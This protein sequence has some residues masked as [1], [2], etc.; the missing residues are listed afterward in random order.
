MRREKSRRLRDFRKK[1]SLLIPVCLGLALAVLTQFAAP[2]RAD[3]DRSY[4]FPRVLIEAELHSDGSMTVVEA[5]SYTHLDVYK[6]QY[7]DC[8]LARAGR[9]Q[10]AS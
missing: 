6:R 1:S 7:R 9:C 4:Y 5:V 2:V 10:L 3:D 8:P